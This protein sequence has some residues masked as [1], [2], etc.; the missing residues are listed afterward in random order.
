MSDQLSYQEL[1]NQGVLLMQAENYGKAAEFFQSAIELDPSAKDGYF[2]LGNA[3]ANLDRLDEALDAFR[4]VTEIDPEDGEAY[5]DIGNLYLLKNDLLRC[6]E[7][8]NTAE[9]RGFRRVELYSTLAAV[10]MHLDE[11]QQAVRTLSKAIKA[12]PL[13]ADL[14]LEKA[15]VYIAMSRFD[16]A[17]DALEETRKLFPDAFEVYDLQTQIY[18]GMKRYDKALEVISGAVERYAEDVV[19]RWMKIKVLVEM[20]R[21]AQ[22][23]EEIEFIRGMADYDTVAREVALQQSIILSME[24]NP[25]GAAEV[26]DQALSQGGTIS[27]EQLR[28]MLMNLQYGL[29]Q[30]EK[31]LENA[32]KLAALEDESLFC[33]SGKYYAAYIRKTL[34]QT[35]AANDTFRK[36]VAEFRRLSIKNPTF[37]ELYMYRL[38]CHKEIGEFEKALQL[39]DYMEDLFPDRADAYAFR[40]LIYDDMGRTAEAEAARAEARKR[41]PNLNI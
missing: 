33:V 36:L 17:L 1:V 7:N 9:E 20:G 5:F 35:E 24:N 40:S 11:G 18:S 22:A 14:R 39:A 37:Y 34:G 26:L 2:H 31:A 4:R 29:K 30:Y 6:V 23:K 8:F 27:D 12:A 25:Q 38:L 10:Y 32:E 16:E 19:L 15:K 41:N 28:F 21:V 13:R 3:M